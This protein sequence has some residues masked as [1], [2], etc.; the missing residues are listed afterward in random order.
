[1]NEWMNEWMNELSWMWQGMRGKRTGERSCFAK[2]NRSTDQPTNQRTDMTSF[3]YS[4]THIKTLS[5]PSPSLPGHCRIISS[6]HPFSIWYAISSDHLSFLAL[7]YT[8]FFSLKQPLPSLPLSYLLLKR[9]WGQLYSD[10]NNNKAG[11]T[12]TLDV[13]IR[14]GAVMLKR[15]VNTPPKKKA[16]TKNNRQK[17]VS[18]MKWPM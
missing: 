2:L 6:L 13:C 10:Y 18:T 9:S 14:A 7:P 12:A 3:R 16:K 8:P 17:Y 1:M 4:R 11:Y 5:I 15:T